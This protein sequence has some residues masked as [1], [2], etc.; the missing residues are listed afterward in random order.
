MKTK[1][2][3]LG[4]IFV[5]VIVSCKKDNDSSDKLDTILISYTKINSCLDYFYGSV[6]DKNGL[7]KITENNWM[8]DRHR[9][10]YFKLSKN[11]LDKLNEELISVSL[12]DIEDMYGFGE[13]KPTD[14][15][16]TKLKYC[17]NNKS[18]ST[19][20]YFPNKNELPVELDKLSSSI[21]QLILNNDLLLNE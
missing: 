6:I 13:D 14:L 7:M 3:L 18:D 5:L 1:I 15:P 17:I 11:D 4:F 10:L 12:I 20:I 8:I 9:V 19:L 21:E 2:I 16:V